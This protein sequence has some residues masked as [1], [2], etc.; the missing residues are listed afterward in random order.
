MM[1]LTYQLFSQGKTTGIFQFE[2]DGMKKYLQGP[3][4]QPDRGPHR[5]ERPLPP[6]PDGVHPQLHQ[7]EARQGEDRLRHPRH[8]KVS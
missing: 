5:H 3:Q 7:P 1:P 6:G 4:A 2:S 8:G